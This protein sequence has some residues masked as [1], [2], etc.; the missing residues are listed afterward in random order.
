MYKVFG[1]FTH[2]PKLLL[3]CYGIRPWCNH[4][5]NRIAL[6]SQKSAS[7]YPARVSNEWCSP[8]LF[9]WSLKHQGDK[10]RNLFGPN[11]SLPWMGSLRDL[12]RMGAA[13]LRS[14]N[15][16]HRDERKKIYST[17]FMNE[18]LSLMSKFLSCWFCAASLRVKACTHA[19]CYL[20]LSMRAREGLSACS[21]AHRVTIEQNSMPAISLLLLPSFWTPIFLF[22]W[23]GLSK[24][25]TE[26]T[27]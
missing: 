11:L 15:G 10:S 1:W 14:T 16:D 26:V 21:S 18:I 6:L 3:C 2:H 17:D 12:F 4:A 7:I 22:H 5:L 23:I 27:N 19:H 9:L 24:L 8:W 25:C 20:S 13:W